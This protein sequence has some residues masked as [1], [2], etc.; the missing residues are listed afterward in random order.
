[1]FRPLLCPLIGFAIINLI[2]CQSSD[3]SKNEQ[4]VTT[5]SVVVAQH[6]R[7]SDQS[8]IYEVN[9]RQYS[10]EG[11]IKAFEGSLQ[12]LKDMGVEILWFMPINPIGLEGRK[13]TEKDL[14]SY[15]AVKDY[16][17]VNSEFGTMDDWKIL[18]KHAHAMGFKVILDWV[19]NHSSPDNFWMTV[20]PA[21]Y[22]RDSSGK[23]IIPNGWDD[24]RKL[25]YDNHELRD[26]MIN[27]MKYWV[28]ESDIDGF[29]C[30]DASDVPDDFW[31]DAISSLRKIKTVFMLAEGDK[32]SLHDAGFDET[33]PWSVMNIAYGIY[34]GKKTL[35]QLDSVIDHNDSVFPRNALRL[36]F[37]T[38]HDENSWNGTEFERFGGDYQAFAVWAFT[39]GNSLPLIYSGQ[40][41]PNRRRLKFFVKDPIRWDK[42][43]LAS[44][45]KTLNHLRRSS[46]ALAGDASFT[47]LTTGKD[48]S[49]YAFVREKNGH[50]VAVFLNFSKQPQQ[51][52]ISNNIINGQAKNVFEGNIQ[53]L[54]AG[55]AISIL[56]GGFL[57]YN[58]DLN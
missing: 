10:V 3:Q 49:V 51:F 40:E 20:H 6:P 50:K 38:N 17:A 25:N 55:N 30:D 18:V 5:D 52:S 35:Q 36:Y 34:S 19:A 33:Y 43:E 27:A 57:I 14:G 46:V 4:A 23:A 31:K 48:E 58:Y 39:I 7:W 37:T 56:P 11:T 26:T 15:Y 32:P 47:K 41:I 9:L 53:S 2:S 12:R 21:F 24:T 22:K 28:R 16:Y 1:M 45:Y 42:F 8:N 44:F 29:R 13:A 54:A